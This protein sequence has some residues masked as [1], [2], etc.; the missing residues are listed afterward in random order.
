MSKLSEEI[1]K[2]TMS[3]FQAKIDSIMLEINLN[4]ATPNYFKDS[5]VNNVTNNMAELILDLSV[6]E[7]A[8]IQTKN[9]YNQASIQNNVL[10]KK[11]E[12]E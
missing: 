10:D 1:L 2:S 7:N 3:H 8:L 12:T 6:N 5:V 4:L 11:N 9:L